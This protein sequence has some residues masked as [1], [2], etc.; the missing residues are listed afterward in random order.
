MLKYF[1]SKEKIWYSGFDEGWDAHKVKSDKKIIS[2]KKKII[3]QDKKIKE[4]E[5]SLKIVSDVFQEARDYAVQL[6]K[7]NNIKIMQVAEEF[8]HDRD[9]SNSIL[10]MC[11]SYEKEVE[12]VKDKINKYKIN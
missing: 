10:Q 1:K 12:P 3:K 5:R 9:I 8:K 4:I 6:D 11:R 7:M 2:L